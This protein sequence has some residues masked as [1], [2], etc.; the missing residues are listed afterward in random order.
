MLAQTLAGVGPASFFDP[1]EVVVT[2]L[3]ALVALDDSDRH[4]P[5]A[6]IERAV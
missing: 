6:R 4:L 1:G 3:G 2:A 5:R